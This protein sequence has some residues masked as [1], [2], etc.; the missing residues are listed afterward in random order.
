MASANSVS[1][2]S[3]STAAYA[4]KGLTGLASGLDTEEMVRAMLMSTQS[5]IDSQ[6]QKIQVLEWKQEQ[7]RDITASL[8]KFQ[9]EHL[10]YTSANNLRSNAFFNSLTLASSNDAISVVNK[11]AA[12]GSSITI[13]SVDQLATATKIVGASGSGRK[14][15]YTLDESKAGSVDGKTISIS[16]DGVSKEFTLNGS[17]T[18]DIVADLNNQIKGKFGTNLK[19]VVNN[20][21]LSFETV[22]ND[23][24]VMVSATDEDV[25]AYLN[26]TEAKNTNKITTNLTIKEQ[27][28]RIG[29]LHTTTWEETVTEKDGDGNDVETTKTVTGYK[30]SVNGVDFKFSE[31]TSLMSMMKDINASKAEV[32]MKYDS[33]NDVFTMEANNTGAGVEINFEDSDGTN[34]LSSLF[35]IDETHTIESLTTSGKNAIVT[36]GG[37]QV[38]RASNS[39]EVD[40]LTVTVK[41][42]TNEATEL[43]ANQ[44]TSKIVDGIK[45]FVEDYNSIVKSV[46]SKVTESATYR[47]YPALTDA[48]KDEMSDKEVEKWEAKSQIGLLRND[49]ILSSM[50]TDLRSQLYKRAEEGGIALYDLGITTNTDGTLKIE[51][52]GKLESQVSTNLEAVKTLFTKEETGLANRINTVIDNYAKTSSANP[53]KLVKKAGMENTVSATDNYIQKQITELK[54]YL[55][56]LQSL[57]DSRKKRYWAQFTSMEKLISNSNAMSSYLT[58]STGG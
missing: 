10:S 43:T 53:G 42:T 33:I 47:D 3:T 51:D 26:V 54:N 57:Y 25:K 2:T 36:V 15:T 16:L 45:K 48:Q 17:T 34:L 38:E 24:T 14:L 7:Y 39:F 5:K 4:G 40:G 37:K 19:A 30:F 11:S 18:E 21:T 52:E 6:N 29:D 22:G 1:N 9:S 50:L 12:S 31:D 8:I 46:Y 49:S 55:K 27:A 28:S 44:D 23:N 41:A 35:N 13:D 32:T 56:T 58:S 20:G